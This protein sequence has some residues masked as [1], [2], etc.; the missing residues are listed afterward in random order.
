MTMSIAGLCR[1]TGSLG[2]VIASSSPAVASRCIWIAPRLGV[3]LT[4]NITDPAI[5]QR[6]LELLA[7]SLPADAVLDSLKQ[8]SFIGWRQVVV[9]D[10]SGKAAAHSGE[11][12]L[13]CHRSRTGND[14]VAAGNLL[15]RPGVVDAMVSRFE[16]LSQ[17]ELP[18]RLLAALRAGLDEGGEAGPVKS[19]GLKVCTRESWPTVD[20]RVDWHESPV[21]ELLKVWDVYRPQMQDYIARALDPSAAPAFGVPGDPR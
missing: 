13:G 5:G 15:A 10:A 8:R 21:D 4:Q 1:R 14:C 11:H 20:L 16:E 6:G 18:E 2:A 3:V 7:T 19:A 9:L 17:A 12:T